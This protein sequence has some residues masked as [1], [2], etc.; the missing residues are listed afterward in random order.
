[1]NAWIETNDTLL[2]RSSDAYEILIADKD[3]NIDIERATTSSMTQVE[4]IS[5]LK[6]QHRLKEQHVKRGKK[7]NGSVAKNRTAKKEEEAT[8]IENLSPSPWETLD[9]SITCDISLKHRELI[10]LYA[11]PLNELP[12]TLCVR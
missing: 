12:E 11:N 8:V 6:S 1:M 5:K 4:S 2:D 10:E 7:K 9:P 3:L